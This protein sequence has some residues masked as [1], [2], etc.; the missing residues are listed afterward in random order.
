MDRF[1][2]L[3]VAMFIQISF[4]LFVF[5]AA[6]ALVGKGLYWAKDG[7][8]LRRIGAISEETISINEAPAEILPLLSQRF[9]YLG[10]GRQSFAFESLDGKYVLKLPRIDRYETK[11]WMKSLPFMKKRAE[12]S[13][14][15]KKMRKDFVFNSFRIAFSEMKE[16][17]GLLYIHLEKTSHLPCIEIVDRIGRSYS[18]SLNDTIFLLQ[19]KLPMGF[20]ALHRCLVEKDLELAKIMIDRFLD[21]A[22]FR[23]KKGIFNRDSNFFMNFAYNKEQF[24]QIDV[25]S[26]HK[27]SWCSKEAAFQESM[28]ESATQIRP[29]IESVDPELWNWTE[30]RIYEILEDQEMLCDI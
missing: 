1:A 30:K 4:R 6:L 20:P 19:K 25:G 29:W 21:L 12:A 3:I 28:A 5:V 15:H 14:Q 8:D 13:V 23:A 26:F 17:T 7:F 24:F 27:K 22:V 18:I 10:R 9:A 11:L 16:Q 2:K